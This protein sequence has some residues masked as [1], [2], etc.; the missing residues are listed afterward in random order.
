MLPVPL[1]SRY[2]CKRSKDCRQQVMP[3]SEQEPTI[4]RPRITEG[5]HANSGSDKICLLPVGDIRLQQWVKHLPVS[6]AAT[7]PIA[8]RHKEAEAREPVKLQVRAR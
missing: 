7:S 6:G 5:V 1:V 4:R 2:I 3:E 8:F